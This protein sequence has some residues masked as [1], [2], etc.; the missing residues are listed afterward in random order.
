MRVFEILKQAYVS[1]IFHIRHTYFSHTI[2][3]KY[4][5]RR[6]LDEMRRSE[7]ENKPL[8]SRRRLVSWMDKF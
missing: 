5:E 1:V 4:A 2:P 7:S 8:T 3:L 6:E